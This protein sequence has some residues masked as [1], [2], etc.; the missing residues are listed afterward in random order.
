M[1]GAR[2]VVD[3]DAVVSHDPGVQVVLSTS[4][5]FPESTASAFEIASR[6]GYDGVE[7]MV[8]TDAVSQDPA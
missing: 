3:S 2:V 1:S 4:S 8:M 7:V 6:L 5:V